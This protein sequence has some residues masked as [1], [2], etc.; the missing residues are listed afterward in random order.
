MIQGIFFLNRAE[1]GELYKGTEEDY[2]GWFR[3]KCSYCIK[4]IVINLVTFAIVN[5]TQEKTTTRK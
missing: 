1:F 2:G 3:S 4:V 5:T